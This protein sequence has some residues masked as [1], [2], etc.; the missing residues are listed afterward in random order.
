MGTL[1]RFASPFHELVSFLLLV[2]LLLSHQSSGMLAQDSVLTFL[3]GVQEGWVPE[4]DFCSAESKE[5]LSCMSWVGRRAAKS[6]VGVVE[7]KLDRGL[8]IAR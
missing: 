2:W 1:R 3:D 6:F 7:G 5:I 4:D 8:Q